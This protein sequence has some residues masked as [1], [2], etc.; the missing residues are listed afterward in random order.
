MGNSTI[1]NNGLTQL[2]LFNQ[3]DNDR[4]NGFT[5]RF[6]VDFDDS[7]SAYVVYKYNDNADDRQSDA[8]GFGLNPFVVQGGPTKL[9]L[10]TYRTTISSRLVN[11]ARGA[12]ASSEP[13]FND[14]SLPSNFIIGGLPL[15]LSRAEASFEPQG[16]NTK[17]Y[18]FQDNVS[19]SFGDHSFRFG[20]QVE[21]QRIE[22]ITNFNKTPIYNITT[23]ANTSTP[24]LAASL[25]PGGINATQRGRAD[26]LRYLLDR[27]SVV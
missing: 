18:T 4:R 14:T 6:D 8:G 9:F 17:Q 26:S 22:S 3:A 1:S 10:A 19:Y 27:K 20:G 2:F 7:N 16:R 5:G 23:T 21:G 12:Y 15:G 13:F 24:R 25:F 11:E